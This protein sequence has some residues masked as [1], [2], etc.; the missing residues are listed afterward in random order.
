MFHANTNFVLQYSLNICFA[1][2]VFLFQKITV[3]NIS[4]PINEF[5]YQK[6]FKFDSAVT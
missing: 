6:T 5:D 2:T 3:Q 4:C 1:F